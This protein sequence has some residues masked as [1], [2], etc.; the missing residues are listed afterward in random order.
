[1]KPNLQKKSKR[2]VEKISESSW[3]SNPHQVN[4]KAGYSGELLADIEHE[5]LNYGYVIND[6]PSKPRSLRSLLLRN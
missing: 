6:F 2:R 3:K 5:I 4:E 1:M